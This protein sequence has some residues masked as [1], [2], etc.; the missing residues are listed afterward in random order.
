MI[1]PAS[2]LRCVAVI[3]FAV[4]GCGTEPTEPTHGVFL[5]TDAR[6]YQL[7]APSAPPISIFATIGN[8]TFA[9]VPVRRCLAGGSAVDPLGAHLVFEQAPSNGAWQAVDL[10]FACLTSSSPRA[11]VVLAPYEVAL[12]ARIVIRTPGRYRLRVGYGTMGDTAPTDTVT[13]PDFTVR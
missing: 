12:V 11:D 10:G 8:Q 6:E 13:S 1:P 5:F 7:S 3:A 4:M 9:S 2:S